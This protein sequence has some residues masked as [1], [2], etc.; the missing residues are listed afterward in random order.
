MA[1]GIEW[2]RWHHGSV[3]DPKFQLVA[4]KAGASLPD[5]LAVWAYILEEASAADVRGEFSIDAEAVDCMFGFEDG[6][7]SSILSVMGA[8]GILDGN[9]IASWDK[10]QPKKEDDTATDRKRRQR[11]RENQ[12]KS[13]VTS[14]ESR[15]VTQCHADVTQCH[16]RGEES[17]EE[18]NIDTLSHPPREAS[19][20]ETTLATLPD[21]VQVLWGK[22]LET[23]R[24]KHGPM[25]EIQQEAVLMELLRRGD[26]MQPDLEMSIRKEAK[27]ILD[28]SVDYSKPQ[29]RGSPG[30][31]TSKQDRERERSEE[32]KRLLDAKIGST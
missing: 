28:S 22:W 26:R 14:D 24:F 7:T 25:S 17:R 2:F 23:R 10:R 21:E 12:E 8:R 15:N 29:A 11:E 31:S 20:L 1:G 19:V 16:A 13:S 3:T 27:N 4:R 30:F 5:V 18:K 32:I 9:R 6:K